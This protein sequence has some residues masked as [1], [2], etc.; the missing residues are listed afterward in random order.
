MEF[1]LEMMRETHKPSLT[2]HYE[3]QLIV[4]K[5]LIDAFASSFLESMVLALIS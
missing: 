5:V 1:P 4:V 2:A 3:R